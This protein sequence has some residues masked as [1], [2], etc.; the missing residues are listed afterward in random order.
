M[1]C[2][3]GICQCAAALTYFSIYQQTCYSCPSG[4]TVITYAY[5]QTCVR[6][7]NNYGYS[8]VPKS[9]TYC[10][11]GIYAT[12]YPPILRLNHSEYFEAMKS[13]FVKT[14]LYYWL[15]ASDASSEGTFL[16]ESDG[17]RMSEIV[18]TSIIPWC[19]RQPG[20]KL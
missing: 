13:M 18:N 19:A 8:L 17:Y 16:W 20:N 6:D 15:S 12:P 7:A 14:D 4:W 3:N 10:Y 5:Q 11:Y 9:T 2:T 1:I